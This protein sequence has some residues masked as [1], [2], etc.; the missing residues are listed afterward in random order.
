MFLLPHNFRWKAALGGVS[1]AT[2]CGFHWQK[3]TDCIQHKLASTTRSRPLLR[4]MPLGGSVT[5]GV[6][7]SDQ[8]GYR[9][10]LL[11]LLHSHGFNV[12]MVGSRKA[13]T[14]GNNEHE[15]WRGFRIDQ[16]EAKAKISVG[17]L[18]PHIFAVNAGSND[19]LQ[20][21]RLAE[22]SKRLCNL[23]ETLW[24][25]SPG[26]TVVLS[27]L[28]VNRDEAIDLRVRTFNKQAK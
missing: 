10:A 15:G 3:A 1:R 2:K 11:E 22:A 28:L 13:G 4:L 21:Y 12:C 18:L 6:G 7:S 5:H 16:I 24:R 19:C 25:A 8:N 14:F 20:G 23:L 17:E 9:K 26:S 27:S